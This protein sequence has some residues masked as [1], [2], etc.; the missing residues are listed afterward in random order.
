MDNKN[1]QLQT[2]HS[3]LILVVEDSPTQAEALSRLLVKEGYDVVVAKDGAEGLA[4]AQK[5]KPSLV[6][7]DIRMPI[8]DGYQMCKEMK[9]S[10]ALKSVPVILLT[11]LIET[12]DIIKGLNSF[13]DSYITKPYN[14]DYL[15]SKTRAWVEGRV[16]SQNKPEEKA[17]EIMYDSKHYKIYSGHGQTLNMLLA[18]YENAVLQNKELNRLQ[19]ELKALNEKLEEKVKERTSALSAEIA[20]RKRAEEAMREGEER[21]KAVV[22]TANDAIVSIDAGGA[23]YLWNRSAEK[24]FGYSVSDIIGK[25]LHDIIVPEK[26][27]ENAAKGLKGF[28]ETGAG[29][30]IGKTIEIAGLRKDGAEFPIELSVSA[31]NI[32]GE[33]HA[34]GIIRDITE[35]KQAEEKLKAHIED[36]ERFKKATIQRELRMKELR[37]RIE[38]MEKKEKGE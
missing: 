12:D 37:D 18:T 4:M 28:F 20:E 35:R 29:D 13:A 36:L 3:A 26:H 10:D 14:T 9:K 34:T 15:V 25:S 31:M 11:E 33:W 24:M 27:R 5:I 30:I 23:V 1:S 7:T 6:I 2:P 32:H 19:E 16:R 38:E 21:L 8:M 22:A 17:A